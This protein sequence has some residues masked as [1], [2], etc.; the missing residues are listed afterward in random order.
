[1]T[2]AQAD[3]DTS[4]T[5]HVPAYVSIYGHCGEYGESPLVHQAQKAQLLWSILAHNVAA[6]E[7]QH[8]PGPTCM[9]E[10]ATP[11]E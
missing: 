4:T 3:A 5:A 10:R 7:V 6:W 11:I 8:R 2:A 9:G 1:M